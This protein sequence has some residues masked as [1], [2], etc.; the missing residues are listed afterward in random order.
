M[1][2]ITRGVYRT[3]LDG[4]AALVEPDVQH[5]HAVVPALLDNCAVPITFHPAI[6]IDRYFKLG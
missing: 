6:R 2:D 5:K 4:L 3:N 1:A